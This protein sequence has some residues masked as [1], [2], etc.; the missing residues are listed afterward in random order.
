MTC[1]HFAALYRGYL[2]ISF[3][4]LETGWRP[5]RQKLF[6]KFEKEMDFVDLHARTLACRV[7]KSGPIATIH[8]A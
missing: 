5:E 3:S 6:K 7:M 4:A 8:N 1:W 2:A